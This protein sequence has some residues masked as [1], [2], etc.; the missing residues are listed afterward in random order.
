MNKKLILIMAIA[1]IAMSQ[2]TADLT[3]NLA[4]TRYTK[5]SDFWTADVPCTGGSGQYQYAC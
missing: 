5:A 2:T 1:M 3:F 4:N